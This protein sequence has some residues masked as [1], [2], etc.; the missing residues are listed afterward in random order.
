MSPSHLIPRTISTVV[1]LVLCSACSSGAGAPETAS[2]PVPSS[3]GPVAE[4]SKVGKTPALRLTPDPEVQNV[5]LEGGLDPKA[6]PTRLGTLK[7]EPAKLKAV[8]RSFT[9]ALGTDCGGCHAKAGDKI[10]FEAPTANVRI[11]ENMWEEWVTGLRVKGGAP[12]YCDSCHQGKASFLDRTDKAS[13]ST[14]MTEELVGR[15]EKS[16]GSPLRC[17]SCHGKPFAAS[18]LASWKKDR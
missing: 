14:W 18:F 4:G 16:D 15:L 5:L 1:A 3:T 12:I 11:A 7:Q 17:E 6:L 13:L 9:L 8:M 10:D 2:A